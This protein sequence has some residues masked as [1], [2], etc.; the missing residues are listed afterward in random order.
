[1]A[2]NGRVLIGFAYPVVAKY[3]FDGTNVTYSDGMVMA[4]GVGVTLDLETSDDNNFY[5]DNVIAESEN[6]AFTGGTADLTVDGMH[7]KAER[8]VLGLPDP[9]EVSY[10]EAKKVNVTKYGG[11]ANPPYL[12]MGYIAVYQSDQTEIYVPTILT[13][14]KM[15]QPK[16]EAKTKEDKKEYQTQELTADIHRDDTAD[17]NWKWIAE[18]QSSLAAAK[19]VLDGILNVT[20]T[21][22]EES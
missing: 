5:A 4:R 10:G 13:K 12:G 17:A 18:D 3:N 11:K 22:G 8:F 1:M 15:R 7:P 20:A 19:A 6:G 9:E 16:F 2:A 14:T 21:A